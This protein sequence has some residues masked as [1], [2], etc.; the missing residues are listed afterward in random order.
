MTSKAKILITAGMVFTMSAFLSNLLRTGHYVG[1]RT[2]FGI[3]FDL[4]ILIIVALSYLL[5][6]FPLAE[7]DKIRPIGWAVVLLL[8]SIIGIL[9][10]ILPH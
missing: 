1:T 5:R 3:W 8:A 4:K 2:N 9:F 10:N 7:N 6:A